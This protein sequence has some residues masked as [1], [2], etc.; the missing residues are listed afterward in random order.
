MEA[1]C[2]HVSILHLGEFLVALVAQ[3]GNK[4]RNATL[5]I[6]DSAPVRGENAEMKQQIDPR[7]GGEY[8]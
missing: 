1:T 5:I 7:R 2:T 4:N 8:R 6:I 3:F